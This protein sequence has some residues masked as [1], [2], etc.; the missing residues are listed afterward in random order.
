MVIS[1]IFYVKVELWI[2]RAILVSSC[3]E[4]EVAALVVVSAVAWLLLVC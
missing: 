1:H 4:E 3:A 2:L